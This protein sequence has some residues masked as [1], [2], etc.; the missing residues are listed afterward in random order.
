LERLTNLE[1][2]YVQFEDSWNSDLAFLDKMPR[3]RSLNLLGS[4]TDSQMARIGRLH[5]LEFLSLEGHEM[6]DDGLSH[7]Q[8]SVGL[9]T[10]QIMLPTSLT[11]RGLAHLERLT[12]LQMLY[13]GGMP[14]NKA[15]LDH[16]R[17]L[18][19]LS[20]VMFSIGDLDDAT[21]AQ[22][23][24]ERPGTTVTISPTYPNYRRRKR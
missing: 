12:S 9:K 7:I 16:L 8:S 21:L 14:M 24:A 1:A 6:T 13:L 17:K 10:L 2:L 20:T 19:S 11:D 5:D 23:K 18:P 15:G 4:V 3:L 22:F